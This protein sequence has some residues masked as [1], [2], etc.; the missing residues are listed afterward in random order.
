MPLCVTINKMQRLQNRIVRIIT[1]N[2]DLNVSPAKLLNKLGLMSIKQHHD[3]FMS[4]QMLGACKAQLHRILLIVLNTHLITI[5]IRL[6]CQIPLC[7]MYQS[8]A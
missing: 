5:F 6:D 8:H 2:Y 4:I 1:N 7:S 3:Y